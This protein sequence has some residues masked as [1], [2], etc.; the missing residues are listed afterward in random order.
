MKL[1]KA[2]PNFLSL[3]KA[4]MKPSNKLNYIYFRDG[5]KKQ[6]YY[7]PEC[8]MDLIRK[9]TSKLCYVSMMRNIRFSSDVI[10]TRMVGFMGPIHLANRQWYI[11]QVLLPSLYYKGG[12]YRYPK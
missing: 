11:D 2:I 1:L 7:N 5:N 10:L 4:M 12:Y 9:D 6:P 8:A 3:L